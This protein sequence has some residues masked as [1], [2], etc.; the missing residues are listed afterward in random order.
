[1]DVENMKT[2][3]ER[4]LRAT[5]RLNNTADFQVFMEWIKDSLEDQRDAN[6]D[7]DGTVLYRGQGKSQELKIIRNDVATASD[8][9]KAITKTPSRGGVE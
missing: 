5:V 9:L 8:T 6:D 3:T 1:L 4:Q 7:L 2:M